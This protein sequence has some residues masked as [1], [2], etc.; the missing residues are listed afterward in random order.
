MSWDFCLKF[1]QKS[2]SPKSLKITSG[3]FL[4]FSKIF[5]DILESRCTTD[6]KNTC[7]N[8][9][10]SKLS[11]CQ[12][13]QWQILTPGSTTLVANLPPVGT[14]LD[15]WYL[16]VNLKEKIYLSVNSTTQECPNKIIKTFLIE[17]FFHLPPVSMTHVPL[18]TNIST[19]FW[20]K[21]ETALMVYSGSGA[22]GKLN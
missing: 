11:R 15:C 4:F 8:I 2:S 6:I 21:F 17:H 5:R 10:G 14:L 12:W 3:S 7:V 13:Q 9:T 18:A 16:K 19:N 20:K 22:R 1:F